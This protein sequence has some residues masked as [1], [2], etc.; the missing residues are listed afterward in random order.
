MV[1]KEEATSL[2]LSLSWERETSGV[3]EEEKEACC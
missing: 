2:S 1:E 3:E